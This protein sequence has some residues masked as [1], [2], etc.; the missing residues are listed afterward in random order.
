M[1]IF[2][3]YT[4]LGH[5]TLD[6]L[7]PHLADTT[8]VDCRGDDWNYCAYLQS[9]WDEGSA[10]INMEHDIVPSPGLIT[11][12]WNCPHDW[13][14]CAYFGPPTPLGAPVLGLA[15]FSPTFISAIPHVWEARRADEEWIYRCQAA[16]GYT[17]RPIR[18]QAW[19]F[20]DCFLYEYATKHTDIEPHQ[21]WPAI[22]NRAA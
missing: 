20:L 7:T 21:H 14:V 22:C 8:F 11:E 4:Q 6:A 13:C 10:F 15:K 18:T 17:G 5:A 12:L 9:R 19:D 16:Q 1:R 2:V 3:P